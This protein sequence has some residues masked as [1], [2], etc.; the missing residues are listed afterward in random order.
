MYNAFILLP[1]PKNLKILDIKCLINIRPERLA[2]T[3][4]LSDAWLA[5]MF[6]NFFVFKKSI[7]LKNEIFSE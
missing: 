7:N 4:N 6:V 1:R 3:C 2:T 5:S